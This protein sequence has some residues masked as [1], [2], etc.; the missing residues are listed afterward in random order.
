MFLNP[1]AWKLARGFA[2]CKFRS[3]TA[4]RRFL[5]NKTGLAQFGRFLDSM[6]L[7]FPEKQIQNTKT[8]GGQSPFCFEDSAK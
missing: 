1:P 8:K 3:N 5:G 4:F 2:S 6:P 7:V